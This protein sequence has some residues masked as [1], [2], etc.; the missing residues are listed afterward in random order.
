MVPNDG[1]GGKGPLESGLEYSWTQTG[2]SVELLVQ[3]DPCWR[4][5]DMEIDIR[6][7]N[8]SI[9]HRATG[10]KVLAGELFAKVK[11]DGML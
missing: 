8:L 7:A 5:R 1:D 4:S 9:S 10:L 6:P 11:P 3:L 2:E